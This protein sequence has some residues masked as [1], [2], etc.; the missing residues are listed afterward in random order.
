[1]PSFEIMDMHGNT[2]QFDINKI[3]S[4]KDVAKAFKEFNKEVKTKKAY[5]STKEDKLKSVKVYE[6]KN[7]EETN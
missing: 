2:K 7:Q 6:P 3:K 1:M 4:A 5:I